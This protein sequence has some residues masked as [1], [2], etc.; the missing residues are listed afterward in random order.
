MNI[1]QN[2]LSTKFNLNGSGIINYN[3]STILNGFLDISASNF[4]TG[5]SYNGPLNLYSQNASLDI[6]GILNMYGSINISNNFLLPIIRAEGQI[7]ISGNVNVNG[8][9]DVSNNITLGGNIY[10][11]SDIKIKN[12]IIKLEKCLEKIDNIKG[13]SYTRIDLLDT[14]KLH[15]GLIAQ[16]VESIYPE[17]ISN[18]NGVKTINYNSMIAILLQCIKELKSEINEL[19]LK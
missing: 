8:N 12:N 7:D 13:Y 3:G 2:N 11:K 14:T 9:I 1:G 6:S 18:T 10:S 19:K 15:I 17:I 16:E 5:I 4:S